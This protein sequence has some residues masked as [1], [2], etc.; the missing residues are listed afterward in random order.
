MHEEVKYAVDRTNALAELAVS[1]ARSGQYQEAQ[2]VADAAGK[3]AEAVSNLTYALR[4]RKVEPA[5]VP[6]A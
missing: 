2:Q 1:L 5:D 4:E 6:Y 3:L